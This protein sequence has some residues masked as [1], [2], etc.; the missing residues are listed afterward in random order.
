MSFRSSLSSR[1]PLRP[2]S[3]GLRTSFRRRKALLRFETLE[4][5]RLF[6]AARWI[7]RHLV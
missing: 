4:D 7:Y 6:S 1:K 5:R 2:S 3:S